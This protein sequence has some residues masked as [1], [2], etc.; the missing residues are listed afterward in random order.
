MRWGLLYIAV[1]FCAEYGLILANPAFWVSLFA[2]DPGV[3][4]GGAQYLV[5][6]GLAMPVYA[7]YFIATFSFQGLGRTTAP[8]AGTAVRLIVIL[9]GMQALEH[10]IGLT[11]AGVFWVGSAAMVLEA[12]TMGGALLILRRNLLARPDHP[13]ARA[14]PGEPPGAARP[15]PAPA[16]E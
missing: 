15:T 2:E 9:G 5:I 1:V 10:G 16:T 14:A 11:V 3:V 4:A 12:V 8:L 13:V 7:I 6:M